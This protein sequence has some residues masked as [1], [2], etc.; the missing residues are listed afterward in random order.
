MDGI[1]VQAAAGEA[2][3]KHVARLYSRTGEDISAPFPI[4]LE[5]LDFDG[6]IDGEL[7]ILRDG[8]VQSFNVLQQRL[9]RKTVNAKLMDGIPRAPARLR[10][11]GRRRQGPARAAVRRAPRAPGE[12]AR[13]NSTTTASTSR[14]W[15]RSTHGTSSPARARR[16]GVRGRGRGCRSGRRRDA[17]ARATRPTC[18][19]GRRAC[20]GSGSATRSSSTPC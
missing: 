20:G 1:R 17:Q 6:A 5:A 19:A 4:S 9:N 8:R 10:S 13:R 11:A 18:R 14:H 16:P 12:A 15:S 2:D 7:L 3:G